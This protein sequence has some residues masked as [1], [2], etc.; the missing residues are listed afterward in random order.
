[1]VAV[2]AFQA[3]LTPAEK[4]SEPEEARRLQVFYINSVISQ[5]WVKKNIQYDY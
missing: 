2:W 3:G 1:M 5:I 4:T